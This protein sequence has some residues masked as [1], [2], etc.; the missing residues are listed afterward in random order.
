MRWNKKDGIFFIGD[1]EICNEQFLY[2]QENIK[3]FDFL[4][5][6]Y[7]AIV[8]FKEYIACYKDNRCYLSNYGGVIISDDY[9]EI[10]PFVDERD[11]AYIAQNGGE[12][13]YSI[14]ESKFIVPLNEYDE[15]WVF[16]TA[17]KVRCENLYGLLD[18]D[19]KVILP[20]RYEDISVSNSDV[21]KIHMAKKNC[22]WYG[23]DG[24]GESLTIKG[25]KYFSEAFY[26]AQ[27]VQELRNTK[28]F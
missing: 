27:M 3:V 22:L 2:K 24:N 9:D 11:L 28:R 21:C 25:C 12:G 18:F 10:C 14:P 8:I 7:D 4:L 23:F 5:E 13:L 26:K 20:V 19:G 15:F 1:F 17:I 16:N 6:R